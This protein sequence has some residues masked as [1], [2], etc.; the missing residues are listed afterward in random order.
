LTFERERERG[1]GR[2]DEGFDFKGR[3]SKRSET[4]IVTVIVIVT[5]SA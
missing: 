4:V 5:E 2:D 1:V 3:C